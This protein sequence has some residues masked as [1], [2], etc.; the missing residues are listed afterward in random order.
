MLDHTVRRKGG[1][2]RHDDEDEN[3][4]INKDMNQWRKVV[5]SRTNGSRSTAGEKERM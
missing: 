1:I 4:Q 2:E 5:K 3:K